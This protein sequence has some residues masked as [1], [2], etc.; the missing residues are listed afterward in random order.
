[1]EPGLLEVFLILGD[2]A[3]ASDTPN[4]SSRTLL[5]LLWQGVLREDVRDG[6][7]ATRLEEAEHLLENKLLLTLRD[8]VD[9]AVGD[10]GVGNAI[11]EWDAGDGRLDELGDLI[12]TFF[13]IFLGQG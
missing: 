10:D 7:P 11:F 6:N 9:D 3:G 8:E 1:M 13:L 4:I 12:S 5:H 2:Q